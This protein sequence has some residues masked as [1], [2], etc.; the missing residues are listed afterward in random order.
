[1]KKNILL[2]S[3]AISISFGVILGSSGKVFA[4]CSTIANCSKD[5]KT[6]NSKNDT[7]AMSEAHEQADRL[8]GYRTD[9][10]GTEKVGELNKGGSYNY[11]TKKYD[12]HSSRPATE[13]APVN[14][15]ADECTTIDA[16]KNAF[17][18]A[19]T[20]GDTTAMTVAHQRADALRGYV[21]DSTGTVKMGNLGKDV[22]TYN[23]ATGVYDSTF[24]AEDEA[25]L[26]QFP[27]ARQILSGY[28][29]ELGD[30]SGIMPTKVATVDEAGAVI[31]R[32]TGNSIFASQT[33][34]DDYRKNVEKYFLERGLDLT[35]KALTGDLLSRMANIA[36]LDV[37]FDIPSN[38]KSING[39]V[40][41]GGLLSF[42]NSAT[43]GREIP[44]P[45]SEGNCSVPPTGR[46]AVKTSDARAWAVVDYPNGG[47]SFTVGGNMVVNWRSSGTDIRSTEKSIRISLM[48]GEET[49]SSFVTENDG[50]ENLILRPD[51]PSG[52]DYKIAVTY[53]YD[54]VG[55][56]DEACHTDCDLEGSITDKSDAS[57]CV[58]VP[59]P[60]CVYFKAEPTAIDYNNT[61]VLSWSCPAVASVTLDGAEQ[62]LTGRT[63]VKPLVTSTYILQ[64]K[65][66]DGVTKELRTTVTV[67]EPPP[68]PTCIFSASP[69][70][71]LLSKSSK[72]I[73]SCTNATSCAINNGIGNVAI[74]GTK[75]VTPDK[76]TTYVLDCENNGVPI[77]AGSP[78]ATV[79][80]FTAATGNPE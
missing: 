52:S 75:T 23:Y 40:L 73:W 7:K 44:A 63:E 42:V 9:D 19:K 48:K 54:Y 55:C 24:D 25:F 15:K 43:E 34:G 80:V 2:I 71:I 4:A 50:S 21:T 22:G 60:S 58:S 69:T 32:L 10:S 33:V 35:G 57:F 49:V 45:G 28:F 38:L 18:N 16:C 59:A 3:L 68:A 11:E 70:E 20:A 65:N 78:S 64:A 56:C 1:M 66:S 27:I 41:R 29:G 47:E 6:A 72:L 17:A 36:G 26:V 12:Y 46:P 77:A 61:A 13:P 8:R 37:R 51:H 14:I 30:P 39:E 79:T 62:L 67:S 31:I 76:T 53:T 5:W 74:S